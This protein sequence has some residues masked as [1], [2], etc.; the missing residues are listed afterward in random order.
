MSMRKWACVGIVASLCAIGAKADDLMT[1]TS[2]AT[3]ATTQE[4]F[5]PAKV[6]IT[7]NTEQAPDLDDWAQHKLKPVLEEWYPK[8]CA[9]LPVP[10]FTPTDHF[11]VTFV[12]NYKG[13]AYTQ[14]V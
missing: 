2:P 3:A 8:I 11:S 12:N 6:K 13:V 9:Q 7:I 4:A 10:G 5:D 14:G 1:A